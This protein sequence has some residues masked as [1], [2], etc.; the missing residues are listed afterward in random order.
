MI[1][2]TY[3]EKVFTAS[4]SDS[5]LTSEEVFVS[6]IS[7]HEMPNMWHAFSNDKNVRVLGCLKY[8]IARL[9][10]R[11]VFKYFNPSVVDAIF[12]ILSVSLH[13]L[14]SFSRE[15]WLEFIH[16]VWIFVLIINHL[17]YYLF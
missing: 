13:R 15:Y 6:L 3:W 7:E 2:S 1:K 8:N 5:P 9:S 10:D 11:I 14:S 16:L 4:N 17:L 12:L